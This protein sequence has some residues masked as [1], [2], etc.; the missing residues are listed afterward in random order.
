[1]NQSSSFSDIFETATDM[2]NIG[3]QYRAYRQNATKI[4]IHY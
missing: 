2:E 1:M 3:N 4:L